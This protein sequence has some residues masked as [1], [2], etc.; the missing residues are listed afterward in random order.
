MRLAQSVLHN[1]LKHSVAE[2]ERRRLLTL[3]HNKFTIDEAKKAWKLDDVNN[4]IT[5][6]AKSGLIVKVDRGVYQKG[7]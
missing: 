4:L 1:A 7:E 6:M 2:N 3:V 5:R